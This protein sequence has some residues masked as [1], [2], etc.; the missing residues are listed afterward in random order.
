MTLPLL[1]EPSW[2]LSTTSSETLL[3]P[4]GLF[5]K[6]LFLQVA[7]IGDRKSAATHGFCTALHQ[8]ILGL[9]K[10]GCKPAM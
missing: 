5:Q 6:V 7:A 1:G 4:S 8:R 3:F 10:T 9:Q 2:I